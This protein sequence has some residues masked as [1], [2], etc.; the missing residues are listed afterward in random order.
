MTLSRVHPRIPLESEPFIPRYFKSDEIFIEEVR[1]LANLRLIS[2]T[3]A[4]VGLLPKKKLN[5]FQKT[6]RQF[7]SRRAK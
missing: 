3:T 1:H 7:Q 6:G 4:T 5:K 2:M